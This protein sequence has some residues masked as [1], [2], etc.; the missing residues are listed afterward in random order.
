M[1]NQRSNQYGF[2][3]TPP[4]KVT[5]Y[6]VAGRTRRKIAT[7]AAVDAAQNDICVLARF[8]ATDIILSAELV[9]DALGASVTGDLGAYQAGDWV[10]GDKA[11]VAGTAEDRFATAVDM[12]TAREQPAPLQIWNESATLTPALSYSPL[13][14]QCALATEP[15]PGTEYDI[16]LKLEGANPAAGNFKVV[17]TYLAGD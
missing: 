10:A 5:P 12:N 13:W 15:A 1:A 14:E 4:T 16:A 7:F 9:N 17:F 11:L 8:K 6:A 3:N 2:L